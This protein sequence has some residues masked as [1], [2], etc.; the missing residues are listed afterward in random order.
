MLIKKF[1]G[2]SQVNNNNRHTRLDAMRNGF[3]ANRQKIL[4]AFGVIGKIEIE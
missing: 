3:S 4:I 2:K 1:T